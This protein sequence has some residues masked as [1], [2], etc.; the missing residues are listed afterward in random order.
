[1]DERLAAAP[2]GIVEAAADGVVRELNDRAA[3]LLGVEAT[4]AA[5]TPIEQVVP[6]SVDNAVPALFDGT[7]LAEQKLSEY[8]PGPDRWLDV[9]VTPVD[10]GVV[11]YFQDASERQR[12]RQRIDE[13]H[14]EIDRLTVTNDLISEILAALIDASAREEIAATICEHLGQ[15][16]IYEFAW[17][18]ER[19]VGSDEV[20]VHAAAGDTGRTFE[21]LQECLDGTESVPERRA[22]ETATPEIV[23]PLSEESSVP[24]PI[25]RGAFADGLQS[26]LAI[27]LTYGSTVYGVVGLYAADREA[28]SE[29]ERESFGTVGE[30]AGFAVNATRHRN[31]LLSDTVV[32]L[33]IRIDDPAAPLV[34]ATTGRDA[35][36]DLRGTVPQGEELLCYLTADGV[37]PESLA[38]DLGADENIDEV[39]VISEHD[40]GGAIEA[41]LAGETPL[42]RLSSQGT[43]INHARFAEGA[44]ECTVELPPAEDVRRIAEAVTRE[45]D[46]EV[47]AKRQR[48]R[49]LSTQ[50]DFREQ[51]SDQLTEKQEN[52]LRTAYFADYFESPRGSSAAEVAQALGITGPTLLHHLRAGQ[53]K[54][55]SSFF[56][57][58]E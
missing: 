26:L 9:S 55:L 39:R 10:D 40:D 32:E 52:A 57:T 35:T 24:E 44:G 19:E 15:T 16:D 54:L 14:G 21:R 38:E 46:A 22:I 13:L 30:I 58:T 45:Y 34:A 5:G 12:E 20:A 7:E 50:Q 53:R 2:V 11:L 42:G 49:E 31:L 8:Y 37:A 36:V 56:E 3:S 27:P 1:M 51:L 6:E 43:T 23:Q 17:V 29:R 47:T 4:S 33:T 28:F 18:G 41:R 25:R 48:E